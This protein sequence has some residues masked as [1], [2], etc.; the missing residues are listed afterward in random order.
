MS[1]R[2]TIRDTIV[3]LMKA[4][5]TDENNH[6][7]YT[8]IDNQ[9]FGDELVFEDIKAYPAITVSLG[10]ERTE[11]QSSGFRWQVMTLYF[12]AFVRSQDAA[13]EELEKLLQDIKTFVDL[14]DSMHYTVIKP[15]GDTEP[16]AVT[17][18]RYEE[19]A[20]DEG[21]MRPFG[22]GQIVISVRYNERDARFR[23]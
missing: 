3:E 2:T 16:R 6:A 10:P 5:M 4:Q 23:L 1:D 18:M 11:L 22:V 17:D 9:V 13:E 20:T 19:L 7:F 12:T 14:N 8:D 21:T 15:N